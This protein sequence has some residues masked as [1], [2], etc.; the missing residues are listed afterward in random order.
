M[1]QEKMYTIEEMSEECDVCVDTVRRA[2]KAYGYS[3]IL[4]YMGHHK[5]VLLFTEF[6]FK[7]FKDAW[8][9]AKTLEKNY[10][11]ASQVAEMA[12]CSTSWVSAIA[13]KNNIDRIVRPNHITKVAYYSKE[14]AEKIIELVSSRK[15]RIEKAEEK[16]EE[17]S[18]P[19][20]VVVAAEL[21]PLITDM[22]FLKQSYFPDV[23]PECFKD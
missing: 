21:H 9:N 18:A 12:G 8:D 4:S 10:Y 13:C 22:R 23:I 3:G 7:T 16:K 2:M 6:Q 1:S 5:T 11:T 15:A 19:K 14:S 17:A 20:E